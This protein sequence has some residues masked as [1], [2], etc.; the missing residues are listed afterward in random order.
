MSPS[1]ALKSPFLVRWMGVLAAVAALTA[2]QALF[3]PRWPRA[4]VLPSSSLQASLAAAGLD[5]QPL[6]TLPPVRG[7]EK[8]LSPILGWRLAG[9]SELRLVHGNVR[10]RKSFQAAFLARDRRELTLRD[11]QLD[12]PIPGSAV[13]LIQAKP[14]FQTCLVPD[15]SLQ[16]GMAITADSLSLA[17]DRRVASRLDTIKGLL[18]LQPTRSFDCVLVSLRSGTSTRP[19]TKLWRDVLNI[20]S[21]SLNKPPRS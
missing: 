7:Y 4:Q 11:R 9:G 14:G 5:P 19:G 3:L 12:V 17:S 20:V 6:V 2:V 15:L 8:S 18:G 16:S 13:G 10:Q 21:A 1:P